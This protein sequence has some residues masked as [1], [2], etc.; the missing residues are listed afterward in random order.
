MTACKNELSMAIFVNKT[1]CTDVKYISSYTSNAEHPLNRCPLLR[2]CC[3]KCGG[4]HFANQCHIYREI[5]KIRNRICYFCFM[6]L[7]RKETFALHYG[8][9]N[10]NCPSHARDRVIVVCY[11]LFRLSQ[12]SHKFKS[13]LKESL[14]DIRLE[15]ESEFTS[16]LL[17]EDDFNQL[18][19]Y[20]N[21]LSF[22]YG[23]SYNDSIHS[24]F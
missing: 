23:Y 15:N 8:P 14:I 19:N 24:L 13:V 1:V 16:W 20:I 18:L 12:R 4:P 22:F 10:R 9:S 5:L 7:E 21:L 3:L 2:D 6:Y 17:T 11:E